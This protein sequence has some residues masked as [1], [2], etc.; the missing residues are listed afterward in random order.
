MSAHAED[1]QAHVRTY[2]VVFAVLAALTVVTVAVSYLDLST[3]M[4]IAASQ[5]T[6][7]IAPHIQRPA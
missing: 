7:D 3:P 5:A 4:A 1:I 6:P 2:V